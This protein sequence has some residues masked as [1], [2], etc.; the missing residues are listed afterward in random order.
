MN[1]ELITLDINKVKPFSEFEA[2]LATLE[3]DGKSLTFEY[4]TKQ[5]NADARSHIHAIRGVKGKLDKRRKEVK[6]GAIA[7]GKE[8]EAAA[9]GIKDR[10]D[11]IIAVHEKPL[12]EIE[13][14][15]KERITGAQAI[16]ARFRNYAMPMPDPTCEKYQDRLDDIS[17]TQDSAFYQ[18]EMP[19][20]KADADTAAESCKESLGGMIA[21]LLQQERDR[22][23]LEEYRKKQEAADA[24]IL[25]NQKIEDEKKAAEL[26]PTDQQENEP[27]EQEEASNQQS[28]DVLAATHT[29]RAH[30]YVV[31]DSD[32]SVSSF[33]VDSIE[34]E[35]QAPCEASIPPSIT[36]DMRDGIAVSFYTEGF[37]PS[38]AE[39]IAELIVTGKIPNVSVTN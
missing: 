30:K 11:G 31:P 18:E 27:V 7:F 12:F 28:A 39:K 6:A 32:N 33:A 2:Q 23:E 13:N 37:T 1:Q 20:Y 21:T 25:A 5:G 10:L 4:D 26:A 16:V 3:E 35:N 38:D 17:K 29:S 19:D 34:T 9:G 8:V 15:E 24:V 22:A 36:G 14:K